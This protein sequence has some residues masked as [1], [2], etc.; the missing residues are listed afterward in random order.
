MSYH[1]LDSKIG[2]K[3]Q[4]SGKRDLLFFYFFGILSLEKTKRKGR[5]MALEEKQ[6]EKMK[7]KMKKTFQTEG[8]MGY[9]TLNLKETKEKLIKGIIKSEAE[10]EIASECYT[11]ILEAVKEETKKEGKLFQNEEETRR[12]KADILNRIHQEYWAFESQFG[13]VKGTVPKKEKNLVKWEVDLEKIENVVANEFGVSSLE[14]VENFVKE[15]N[16]TA[17]AQIN[18]IHKI[19]EKNKKFIPWKMAFGD[20]K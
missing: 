20:K 9:I 10:K 17:F 4:V 8:E 1:I 3:K 5:A 7:Q 14:K 19:A 12:E 16:K 15:K 6:K 11:Q 2:K 18:E 13:K